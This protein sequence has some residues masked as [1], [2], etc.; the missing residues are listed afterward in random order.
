MENVFTDV[1][2]SPYKNP[3]KSFSSQSSTNAP[4]ANSNWCFSD[5]CFEVC[6]KPAVICYADFVYFFIAY[7]F[8]DIAPVFM[9]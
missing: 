8:I 2:T 3:L 7:M 6:M 1:L 4:D 9:P 5:V